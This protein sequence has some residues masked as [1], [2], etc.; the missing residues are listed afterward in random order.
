MLKFHNPGVIDLAAVTTL[1]VS[2]KTAGAFGRFG[3]GLK[4][5]VASIL[6]GG[7]SIILH[8]GLARHTFG[9]AG[10]TIRGAPFSLVTIKG[11][12]GDRVQELGFTTDLGKDWEP[13]MVLRELACNSMDEGGTFGPCEPE[14]EW[15][16]D[17][18]ET[19]TAFYVE[20]PA[21]EE[22]YSGRADLFAE[23]EP[24]HADDRMRVLAGPSDFAYYRGVRVRK[25]EKPSAFRYDLLVEQRLTEDRTLTSDWELN[26]QIARVALTSEDEGLVTGIVCAGESRFESRVR[27]EDEEH[28]TV[29]KTFLDAVFEARGRKDRDLSGHALN[30]LHKSVRKSSEDRATYVSS[31]R[32]E[33]PFSRALDLVNED[34]GLELPEDRKYI[35]VE[36]LE[37]GALSLFQNNRVYLSRALLRS[38]VRVIAEHLVRRHIDSLYNGY[39]IDEVTN[40]LLQALMRA[41]GHPEPYEGSPLAAM[42]AVEVVETEL[43]A[44]PVAAGEYAR[45]PVDDIPF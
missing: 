26:R 17:R 18:S 31:H 8:A 15:N 9:T 1:G 7:G 39:A 38:P 14:S 4:F 23:G 6:R 22:A 41:A 42:E 3:T 2:V 36:E 29:S 10:R 27:F 5:A 34:L 30:A 24:I 32:V 21:L 16:T 25:L 12:P 45:A 28:V 11:G 13:W 20:W 40:F 33:D 35:V 37:D 43:L 44:P 19:D